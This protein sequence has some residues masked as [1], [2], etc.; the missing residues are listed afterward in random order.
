[1]DIQ[2]FGEKIGGAK[3]D[4]WKE[5]GLSIEDL[6]D[7]NDAE[8]SKLI[9]KDNI[10]KKPNYQELV[11]GGLPTRVAY[12]I[13]TIRD[14]LPTKPTFLRY[15]LSQEEIE[16]RLEDYI[17]FVSDLRDA[18]MSLSTE[19]E[20]LSFYDNY[21]S[22]Y[23]I[24]KDSYSY[25]VDV[26]PSAKEFMNNKLLRASHIKNFRQIDRDIRKKEFCYTDD[27]KV[28]ANF[29]IFVYN[30]ENVEFDK[31]SDG[32]TYM[33]LRNEYSI[34]FLYPEG[35]LINPDN[36]KDNTIFI[37]QG[38]HIIKNNLE[39]IDAAEKFILENYKEKLN[40]KPVNNQNRKKR[41]VPKQL[42]NVTRNGEDYRNNKDVTGEDMM[43]TFNFKGGEFGNWLSDNDRQ[44]SLNYGYDALLDLSKALSILPTDI[45]LGGKLSIAF[46]SRGSGSALA[47]Y[48]PDREV[49]NLTKMK[50][51]GSLAHEWGHALDD[52]MGKQL[53]VNG[54]LTENY[55]YSDPSS[56]VIKDIIE[57]M[58]YKMISGDEITKKQ[59]QE[60]EK[61]INKTKNVINSFFPE[62]HLTKEQLKLKDKL[63]Q[64]LIDNAE[65]NNEKFYDYIST[66]TGIKEIDDLSDLRKQTVGRAI[67]KDERI[68]IAHL[69]NYIFHN[70][71]QI[72]KPVRVKTDFYNNS[73]IFDN[74]YS[75]TEHGYWQSKIEMFA[76]AF[77]CY[78]SDKL[79]NRSD[80][81]CGHADL[82]LGLIPN[83][84]NE[85]E[86]IKAFPE[87][88]ERQL[89]NEKID[90]LIQF[91]KEKN[92][93]HDNNK[94]QNINNNLEFDYDY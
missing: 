69:Q 8:K 61:H 24:R 53:G 79:N 12:F 75:K 33:K 3:K 36:W 60:Y 85:L 56:E 26:I 88:E 30:K 28:L 22:K 16:G 57:T 44:Q 50:G 17:N 91:L 70:K 41:F 78:V 58:Q 52:I 39:S 37:L 48:E 81:L 35:E 67:S 7:M 21:I 13:K 86:L 93:L 66:G 80:Y 38:R 92:I 31:E 11:E 74:M 32:R 94:M 49:I 46:G 15:S 1:M 51:A 4:L 55:R 84:D 76:R 65:K 73:I 90:K 23:I 5:R 87:G 2:D 59:V 19:N 10:W 62:E 83:K 72:G 9:T 14:A 6:L 40:N 82:A 71:N 20:V 89:I 54:F 27:E 64:D 18:A 43:N 45:S 42:E 25:Y 47:H 68:N 77:A 29:D 63:I 34:Y